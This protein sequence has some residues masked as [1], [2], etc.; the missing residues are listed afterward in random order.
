MSSVQDLILSELKGF[1]ND[2][3]NDIK[4]LHKKI[5]KNYKEMT[6]KINTVDKDMI[7]KFHINDKGILK[8]KIKFGLAIS[9]I[10]IIWGI[11]LKKFL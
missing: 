9:T 7:E 4:D 1:R 5:D 10:S 8:N 6:N 11:V 3:R 2:T